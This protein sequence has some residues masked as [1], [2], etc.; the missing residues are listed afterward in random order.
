MDIMSPQL[1]LLS[2]KKKE[3]ALTENSD[4]VVDGD[5]DDV[6]VEKKLRAIELGASGAGR[7]AAA[8]YPDHDWKAFRLNLRRKQMRLEIM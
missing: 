4:S 5:Q 1:D 2:I 8:M 6:V 3:H 7:E